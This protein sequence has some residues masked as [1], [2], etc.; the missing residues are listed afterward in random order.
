MLCLAADQFGGAGV[1]REGAVVGGQGITPPAAA[2][3]RG[4]RRQASAKGT[5]RQAMA[6]RRTRC[7]VAH[8]RLRLA[9][10]KVSG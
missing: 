9:A 5:G 4:S 7:R 10:G 2:K 8:T 1:E 6:V 3:W